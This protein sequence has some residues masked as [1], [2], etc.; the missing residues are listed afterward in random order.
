MGLISLARP[1]Q[2]KFGGVYV[3]VDT[4][5]EKF[6]FFHIFS[7]S[8]N[9]VEFLIDEK[10]VTQAG[11]HNQSSIYEKIAETAKNEE[12]SSKLQ[13]SYQTDDA[14]CEAFPDHRVK[15]RFQDRTVLTL[16]KA[17]NKAT[18][19]TKLGDFLELTLDTPGP[20]Y[21]YINSA[22]SFYDFIFTSEA[23]KMARFREIEILNNM[24]QNDFERSSKLVDLIKG[25][26][27]RQGRHKIPG[28]GQ[29]KVQN[30]FEENQIFGDNQAQGCDFRHS[31]PIFMQ[32]DGFQMTNQPLNDFI[33]LEQKSSIEGEK[34]KENRFNRLQ[35]QHDLSSIMTESSQDLSESFNQGNHHRPQITE[36]HQFGHFGPDETPQGPQAGYIDM[37]EMIRR[38]LEQNDSILNG[39]RKTLSKKK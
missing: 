26:S 13:K 16:N 5:F 18:I 28:N 25:N 10:P 15:L 30:N 12:L 34:S 39:I 29:I 11:R 3:S 6:N 35:D 22:L 1:N 17:K 24:I 33:G 21:H 14:V 20:Y 37:D 38:T 32:S 7:V 27:R 2:D 19:L 9:F 31:R 8:L 36:N 4:T 23:E